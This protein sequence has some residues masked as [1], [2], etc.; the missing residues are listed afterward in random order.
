MWVGMN[1]VKIALTLLTIAITVGPLLGMVY[2]Y[3]DNLLG[4]VLP[5]DTQG[6]A[7]LTNSSPNMAT[8]E[9]LNPISSIGNPTYDQNTG[10][11]SYPVNFTNP[12]PQQISV[13]NLSANIVCTENGAKLGT[14]TIPNSLTLQPG[15]SSII[16][17]TGNINQ[18]V[19]HQ[20]KSQYGNGDNVN[21]SLENFNVT[22][23]G[24]T[25]HLDQISNIGTIQIP[26]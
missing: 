6:M 11:F 5:P 20:Y 14:V 2:I 4:L 1:T 19:L 21:V 7:N 22:V 15:N 26:G 24:V 9:N 16:D 13:E 12:L 10:K 25:L 23:G 8:L 3:R 17:I 18:Q